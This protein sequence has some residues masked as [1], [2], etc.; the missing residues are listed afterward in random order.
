MAPKSK[1]NQQVMDPNAEILKSLNKHIGEIQKNQADIIRCLNNNK[2][3]T[4]TEYIKIQKKIVQKLVTIMKSNEQPKPNLEMIKML[5]SILKSLVDYS[6]T[7]ENNKVKADHIAMYA[8][9]AEHFYARDALFLKQISEI[10]NIASRFLNKL[11]MKF[12]FK[13]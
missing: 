11:G 5:M 4:T 6:S 1:I 10:Y 9:C 13:N 7:M 8:I 2:L 3:G 12:D